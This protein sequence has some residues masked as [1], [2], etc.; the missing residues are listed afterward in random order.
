[1]ACTFG[2][3]P[4]MPLGQWRATTAACAGSHVILPR[5]TKPGSFAA[6]GGA[7][8]VRTLA[9]SRDLPTVA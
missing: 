6:G 2:P 1:M 3:G 7:G 9:R 4:T 5:Q 8:A